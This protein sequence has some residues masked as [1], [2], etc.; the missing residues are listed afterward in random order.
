MKLLKILAVVVAA[1]AGAGN[2]VASDEIQPQLLAVQYFTEGTSTV[3]LPTIKTADGST[4]F[5]Y[6]GEAKRRDDGRIDISVKQVC[7]GANEQLTSL[8][9]VE[10]NG[11]AIQVPAV[12]SKH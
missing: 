5:S 11:L 1:L 4:C 10:T 6:V 8:A 7:V 3:A 9:T 12:Q 2:A